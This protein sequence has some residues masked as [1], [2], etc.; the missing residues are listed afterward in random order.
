MTTCAKAQNSHYPPT[1]IEQQRALVLTTCDQRTVKNRGQTHRQHFSCN[2]VRDGAPH[3]RLTPI[4][5]RSADTT[6]IE[7]RWCDADTCGRLVQQRKTPR[8]RAALACDTPIRLARSSNNVETHAS[9]QS[10]ASAWR[11][12]APACTWMGVSPAPPDMHEITMLRATSKCGHMHALCTCDV[13][14]GL[15]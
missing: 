7:P 6:S 9:C 15:A 8:I 5:A 11:A 10:G 13:V 3:V 14:F 2:L 12:C 4:G 1:T